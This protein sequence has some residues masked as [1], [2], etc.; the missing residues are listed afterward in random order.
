MTHSDQRDQSV[1]HAPNRPRIKVEVKQVRNLGDYNS[2]SYS[3]S[4]EDDVPEGAKISETIE[5]TA[6]NLE[7][8]LEKKLM[9]YSE[10]TD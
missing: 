6:K 2:A 1:F 4:V 10:L 5:K 7:K 3:Y 8:L 9:E